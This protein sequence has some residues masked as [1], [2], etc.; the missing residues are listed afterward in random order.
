[1]KRIRIFISSVQ[2]EFAEERAMLS[3]YIRTDALLG[4]FFETFIFE[5]VP[6]NEASPQQV[7]LN[8]VEMA[9][10]YL[11]LY[12]N[13][14]GYEDEE[15]VSPTERE[16]DRAAELHKTRLVFIKSIDEEHRHSKEA[17]LIRKVERDIVRKTFVDT[18]G[19]RTSV[20]A[21]LV[22]Y[23]EEK[24]YIRW[25]PFDAAFDTNAKLD[26]LDEDKMREFIVQARAKR[27]FP[28]S[29]NSSPE[30]LLAHLSLMDDK[31][32]IANPAILL[33]GKRP[34]RFFITSEVKCVQFF[35][36]VVE[37]PLPAYQ[38]CRGTLFEMIDQAT[39]FVMDRVDLAV[40][41]RAE[42]KTASVP[43]DYEL[44]PDAVKE[45]IV[46][47]VA[48]RDYTSN[49]SVQV[50]LFRNRLEVWNPGRLPYGLTVNKLLEPHKSLPANPLIADPLFWTG[51]VDKVGT[52]TEDIV[53]L[54]K[55]KGLKSPEYHQEEDFRVVIWRRG[56]QTDNVSIKGPSKG[57]SKGLSKGLSRDQVCE[58]LNQEWNKIDPLIRGLEKASSAAELRALMGMNNAT[59]FK[60]N[61][62]DPLIELGIVRMTDPDS[63]NSPKQRYILT[64]TAKGFLL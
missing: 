55:D 11:G 64:D 25:Q 23:L 27:N 58:H 35:G 15:G 33:F 18:E 3:Q 14:Y 53:N 56:G 16:Y 8:E 7:Y 52:G 49:G 45:A 5:D 62:L 12:G 47:A 19:L 21:S 51:Y 39:A 29:E 26:D 50:M 13:K 36:N 4:K 20:Y 30:K 63:P 57:P 44:P 37:K 9:D 43:T 60:K 1:M 59:K 24:E 54:C 17:T 32:R 2:S 28:L 42:G 31:G 34:Q 46:N 22:R 38:I 48:H 6:A 10:I 61:Y 40:G 41:T